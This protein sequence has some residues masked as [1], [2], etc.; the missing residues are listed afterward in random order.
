MARSHDKSE[1]IW[2][3]VKHR[4]DLKFCGCKACSWGMH[5]NNNNVVRRARR[6]YR[7]QT[8]RLLKLM[9]AIGN[10]ELDIPAKKAVGY[11][12]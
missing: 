2:W 5:N 6:A 12:D 10:Y 8:K 4:S 1:Q 11:T 3:H 7:A 9:V